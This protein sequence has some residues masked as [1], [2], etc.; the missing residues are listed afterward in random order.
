MQVSRLAQKIPDICRTRAIKNAQQVT[1]LI[2]STR[3]LM[4]SGNCN[5][6]HLLK[7]QCHRHR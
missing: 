3:N 5:S 6:L 2:C 1:S 4:E 7:V